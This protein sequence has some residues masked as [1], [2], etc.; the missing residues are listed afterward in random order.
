MKSARRYFTDYLMVPVLMATFS[1][2]ASIY[3]VS[4]ETE[5]YN[6]LSYASA[7]PHANEHTRQLIRDA[8]SDGKISRWESSEILRAVLDDVQV[9]VTCPASSDC[10]SLTTEQAR[11]TLRDAMLN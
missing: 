1:A 7:W 5:D 2:A 8:L 4:Q 9:L 3:Y 11:L 6:Y 10:R